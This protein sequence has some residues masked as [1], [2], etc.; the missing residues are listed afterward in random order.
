MGITF[1]TN[2]APGTTTWIGETITTSSDVL[3]VNVE[4]HWSAPTQGDRVDYWVS[5]DN[6]TH[7]ESVEKNQTI[8]FSHPGKEL[9]WKMQLI[10]SSAVSWWMTIEYST[11]YENS[12]QWTSDTI[13]TGTNVGKVRAVW[14]DDTPASGTVTVMVSN[15]NG[16]TWE[17][18]E[19][20]QEVS[21]STQGGGNELLYAILLD[22]TDSSESPK[23]DLFTLW[24]E[25]GYPDGPQLDVGD[26]GDWDWQ[27]ILFLNESSVIASDES[28][29]IFIRF[30]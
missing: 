15:D 1:P 10:G 9:V 8:H 19:N 29:A 3:S 30:S 17:G 25:E 12:G 7:W 4:N 21:F 28:I 27:S 26:D 6:G 11:A 20:N 18:A 22:T 5:A 13:S 16:T 14:I 2:P 24:Y 23:I